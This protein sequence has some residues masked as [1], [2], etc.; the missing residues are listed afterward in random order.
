MDGFKTDGGEMV[1]GKELVFADGSTG[2]DMRNR[3]PNDYIQSYYE[4]AQQ[5]KGITFSRSSYKG[6]QRFPAYWAGDERSTF[7]AFKRSLMAGINAGYS[8]VIFWGWDLAGINV[9][10][11]TAELFMR[12]TAMVAF[13]PIMQYH[14][15]SKGEFNQDR[16][17]WNIAERTGNSQVIDVYRFY[18]TVRMN[19]LPHIYSQ[20]IISDERYTLYLSRRRIGYDELSYFLNRRSRRH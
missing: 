19:L 1:Y 14:A 7:D 10:I 9:D 18:A 2:S 15:E 12:S 16:T 13:C 17:P 11:P 6:A 3:Y 4:F 5:N 8:G 20:S